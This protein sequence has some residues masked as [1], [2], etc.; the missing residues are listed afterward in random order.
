MATEY[1]I[2]SGLRPRYD[3]GGYTVFS[4]L[5]LH[6]PYNTGDFVDFECAHWSSG[7]KCCGDAFDV[8]RR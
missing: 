7:N 1:A 2:R 5:A 8:V 3:A 4:E 6:D